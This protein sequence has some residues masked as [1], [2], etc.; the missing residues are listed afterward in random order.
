MSFWSRIAGFITG[1]QTFS[2]RGKNIYV[3]SNRCKEP[4]A[5]QVDLMNELSRTEDEKSFYS[6]KVLHTSGDSRCFD[7]VEVE[8]W[9]DRSKR[10]DRYEVTGGRWL[11]EDEYKAELLLFNAPP[12]E[13]ADSIE[14]END[15]ESAETAVDENSS[16][17]TQETKTE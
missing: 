17:E 16:D 3:L 10:I 1:N 14:G 9:F 7:Q 15:T 5:G 4:I 2:N 11:E 13:Q 12:D 8:L 6:R